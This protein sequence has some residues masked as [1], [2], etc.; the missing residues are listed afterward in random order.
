MKPGDKLYFVSSHRHVPSG[1]V[2]VTKV[3]RK[4]VYLSNG[5]RI[6]PETLWADGKGY[7]S[8]GRCHASKE[9]HDA[10]VSLEK[11]WSSLLFELRDRYGGAPDGMTVQAID[12]A[13]A[14]L[15]LVKKTE[16]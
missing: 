1:D 11:A 2:T 3:G 10:A 4:W 7:G 15:G 6:N 16:D 12:E 9:A 13:R 14:L 8:P 5:E